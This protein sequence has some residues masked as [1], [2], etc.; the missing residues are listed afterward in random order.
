MNAI[1]QGIPEPSDPKTDGIA[2][3]HMVWMWA[4]VK[5]LGMY[6][7]TKERFDGLETCAGNWKKDKTFAENIAGWNGFNQ[8]RG[9]ITQDEVI[10]AAALEQC[11]DPA[12]IRAICSEVHSWF[13]KD[14]NAK[15]TSQ[16]L[17]ERGWNNAFSL[18]TWIDYPGLNFTVP[19]VILQRLTGGLFGVGGGPTKDKKY[20]EEVAR[21][22]AFW[23]SVTLNTSKKL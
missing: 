4:L 23:K 19:G 9:L 12:K 20:V 10:P 6:E 17:E 15:P 21:T 11:P 18:R 7:Y 5:G 2:I 13:A 8:G 14:G 22:R 16:Q 3:A 1:Y